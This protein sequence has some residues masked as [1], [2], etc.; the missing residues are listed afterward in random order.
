MNSR[1]KLFRRSVVSRMEIQSDGEFV[2]TELLAKANFLGTLMDEI[3]LADKC[4][5]GTLPDMSVD[6]KL[7]FAHPKF[8]SPEA[9]TAPVDPAPTP[10]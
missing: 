10:A 8:R 3:V 1:F 4:V 7:V 9:P 5:P 6:R 2:H